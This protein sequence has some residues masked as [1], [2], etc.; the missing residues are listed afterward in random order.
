M[1]RYRF[2]LLARRFEEACLEGVRTGEIHGETHTGI[3]QEAV[4]AGMLGVLRDDDALVSTHR[5]HAHALAKGVDPFALMAEIFEKEAGLCGGFGGHMHT[6]DLPRRYSAT[7]IV[8][9][10]VPVAL[11][12]AYAAKLAGRDA[13]AVAMVGDGAVNSGGFA[14]AANLAGAWRLPLVVVI[15]NNEWAISVPF[16]AV[17]ATATL[18]ER[19]PAFGAR[20]LRVD[21]NDAEAVAAAFAEAVAQARAGFG[22]VF[23]EATCYRFR[24]HYEGDVDLYRTEAEKQQRRG[25]DP[26]ALMHATMLRRGFS[27][28]QLAELDRSVTFEVGGLL[29][30][31]RSTP[32][33]APEHARRHVF[34]E[35][36]VFVGE[37]VFVAEH[38][39]VEEQAPVQKHVFVE[40]SEAMQ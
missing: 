39:V 6:F 28:E 31:V 1:D 38:V 3:G 15:E 40:T 16:A 11:G 14:E 12:H 2:M 20:G 18:A 7:G 33:P 22:P 26:V 4:A 13:V 35:E 8:G 9:G 21:G 36:Q 27:A 5:N 30:Q 25:N 32:S 37:Q 17:S 10:N 23:V 29:A 24:G 19:A 34:V